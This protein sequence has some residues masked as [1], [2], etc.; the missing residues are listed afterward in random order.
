M[1]EWRAFEAWH[2]SFHMHEQG[3]LPEWQWQ[4][5]I[6]VIKSQFGHRQAV[7]ACWNVFKDSYDEPFRDFMSQHLA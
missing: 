4:K 3:V 5:V 6:W 7:V 1:F 2:H